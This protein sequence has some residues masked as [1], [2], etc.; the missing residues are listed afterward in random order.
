LLENN[1]GFELKQEDDSVLSIFKNTFNSFQSLDNINVFKVIEDISQMDTT[2]DGIINKLLIID[3][4]I[5]Q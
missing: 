3:T 1:K 2:L 5:N 4:T